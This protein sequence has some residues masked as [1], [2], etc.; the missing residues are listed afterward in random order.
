MRKVQW[1]E[2][3]CLSGGT[4]SGF[5]L[6]LLLAFDHEIAARELD[7]DVLLVEPRHLRS[8]L[9]GI[10]PFGHASKRQSRGRNATRGSD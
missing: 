1:K 8:D 6:L 10:V 9:A 5:L 4:A 3:K 2:A 7:L